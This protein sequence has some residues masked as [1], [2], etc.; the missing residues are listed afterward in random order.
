[1]SR[2]SSRSIA[3]L[4]LGAA[5]LVSPAA[6]DSLVVGAD[7]RTYQL[8]RPA[9]ASRAPLV[10]VLH[11]NGGTGRQVALHTGWDKLAQAEGFAAVFPDAK[12]GAWEFGTVVVGAPSNPDLRFLN[13]LIATLVADGTADPRRVYITGV[14]RGGAMTYAM[15]CGKGQLFAAAAPV[16]TGATA[17]LA[18]TCRPYKPMPMLFMNGTADQL[19]P[20][21]GGFGTGPTASYNL[22][23]VVDF[24]AF[25]R[26]ANGCG[27]GNAGETSLPDLDSNDKSTVKLITS[28]CQEGRD[29]VLYKIVGGGHQ[30]PRRPASGGG[31]VIEPQL[32][33]QNHDINGA[34]EIW[35]FFQRFSL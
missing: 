24:V 34:T 23:P 9:S 16:I 20:Y 12:N 31:N 25:W 29:V 33:A 17:D 11:G 21:N 27:E 4:V 19:I 32:G 2:I 3:G 26:K 18:R 28:S 14:S 30:Q 35:R 13:K 1:M 7:L 5:C 10:L 15:V 8:A 6:A 22:M